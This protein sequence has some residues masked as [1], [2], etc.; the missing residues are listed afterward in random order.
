MKNKLLFLIFAITLIILSCTDPGSTVSTI[1]PSGTIRI[2]SITPE[3]PFLDG[4]SYNFTVKIAYTLKN[5][6][7]AELHCG[8]G[9]YTSD[10]RSITSLSINKTVVTADSET[11]LTFNFTDY[12]FDETDFDNYIGASIT[13]ITDETSYVS[14]ASD[15]KII[16][17]QN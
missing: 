3:G 9:E 1:E 14:Y 17:V 11:F 12:I 2:V 5:I 4:M 10:T 6:D 13:P 15:K 16:E 8:V 7:K